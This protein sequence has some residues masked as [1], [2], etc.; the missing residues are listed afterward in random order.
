M[1]CRFSCRRRVAF[2]ETD[3]AGI[4]HFS[5]FLRWMEDAEHAFYR[6]LGLSV[7]PSQQGFPDTETGWP[8]LK[9]SA[10]Y[11]QPLQFEE[12]AEIEVLVAE[13]RSKAIR[14]VFHIW[15]HP[16]NPASR[17]LAASGEFVVVAVRATP[18]T[19]EM[20]ATAIPDTFRARIEPA[21][22]HLLAPQGPNP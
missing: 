8:R 17:S 21:P 22:D 9:V 13:M 6:S 11:R 12:E 18:G 1:A 16:D 3:L 2:S 10:E 14:L 7:H 20:K 19:R 15:K 5:V 4:M